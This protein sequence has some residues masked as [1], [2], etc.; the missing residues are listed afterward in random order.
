MTLAG[1]TWSVLAY[2]L[3]RKNDLLKGY[4]A[5]EAK[6]LVKAA[7]ETTKRYANMLK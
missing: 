3:R 5:Q 4:V 2:P 7:E 1:A 6:C